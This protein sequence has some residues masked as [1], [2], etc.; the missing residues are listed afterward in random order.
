M[1]SFRK[2]IYLIMDNEDYFNPGDEAIE[3][4]IDLIEEANK[5]HDAYL[6]QRNKEVELMQKQRRQDIK[7]RCLELASKHY[8]SADAIITSARQFYKF[9]GR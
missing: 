6:V 1:A 2:R 9:I 4:P 7:M 8:N 3:Q 5:Q